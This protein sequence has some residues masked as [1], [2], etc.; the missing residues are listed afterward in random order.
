MT[1]RF[2][3]RDDL[4]LAVITLTPTLID[5]VVLNAPATPPPRQLP[6]PG[7]ATLHAACPLML[8]G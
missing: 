4:P 7:S 6:P 8:S 2:L 3:R 5:A 1:T